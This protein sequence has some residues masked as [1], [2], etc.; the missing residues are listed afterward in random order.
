[1]RPKAK[2]Q[3]SSTV[4]KKTSCRVL[5]AKVK[6]SKTNE[7]NAPVCT[8]ILSGYLVVDAFESYCD[9]L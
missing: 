2:E 7:V 9:W 5:L 4:A 8:L 3:G 1:M 6:T